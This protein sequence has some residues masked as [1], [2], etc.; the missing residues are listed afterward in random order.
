[1]STSPTPTNR[2]GQSF[3]QSWHLRRESEISEAAKSPPSPQVSPR[4]VEPP[5]LRKRR[6]DASRSASSEQEAVSEIT[7]PAT[8]GPISLDHALRSGNFPPDPSTSSGNLLESR[9]HSE[10]KSSSHSASNSKRSST[11]SRARKFFHLPDL[12]IAANATKDGQ[13]P[14]KAKPGFNWT[15]QRSGEHWKES[16]DKK[17]RNRSSG[18]SLRA[19]ELAGAP[20]TSPASPQP[21]RPPMTTNLSFGTGYHPVIT[22][23]TEFTELEEEPREGEDK[24]VRVSSVKERFL[25]RPKRLFGGRCRQSASESASNLPF[26]RKKNRTLEGLDRVTSQLSHFVD[27]RRPSPHSSNSWSGKSASSRDSRGSRRFPFPM[28]TQ[29]ASTSLSHSSSIRELRMGMPPSNTPDESATYRVR[30]TATA[31]SQEFMRIDISQ[32]GGTSYLPSEA[33]RIKT[34]PLSSDWNPNRQSRGFFFDYHPPDVET[35]ST[36]QDDQLIAAQSGSHIDTVND[37]FNPTPLRRPKTPWVVSD[38]DWN[39][40]MIAEADQ[41]EEERE[42]QELDYDIPDHLPS[43]PLCPKHP[44]HKS[45]GKGVCVTHGRN[46]SLT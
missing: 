42:D 44:K 2:G 18:S 8:V 13:P 33:R 22:M 1:M 29:K 19:S 30:G 7:L 27:N 12:R 36:N 25:D 35:E 41:L 10:S 17:E 21:L 46:G 23:E 4:H 20:T 45:G 34:P 16:N 5:R 11:S 40:V 15:R 9:S 39:S 38:H 3:F 43:S 31:R 6:P 14:R 26:K 24:L 28:W 37:L 32:P